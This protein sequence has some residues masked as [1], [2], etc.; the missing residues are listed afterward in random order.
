MLKAIYINTYPHN[1][2]I[3]PWAYRGENMFMATQWHIPFET[4]HCNSDA[5]ERLS[6][7]RHLASCYADDIEACMQK[8]YQWKEVIAWYVHMAKTM[9]TRIWHF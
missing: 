5:S 7:S 4:V 9:H 8:I 3:S 2:M 6:V 1:W